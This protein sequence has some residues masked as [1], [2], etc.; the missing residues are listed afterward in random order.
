MMMFSGLVSRISTRSLGSESLIEVVTTGMVMRKMMSST[1]ITS[2]RGV[3]LMADMTA[4]SPSSSLEPTFMDMGAA[5]SGFLDRAQYH[6]VQVLAEGAHVVHDGFVASHQ[7]VV[8]E[9]GGYRYG[10]ADGGHEQGFTDRAGD[11]VDGGLAGDANRSER[12]VDAPDGAKQTNEWG[13]GADGGQKGQAPLG[14]ALDAF[15][16]TP[17]AQGDP[18]VEV[19]MAHQAVVLLDGAR[20]EEH[21]SE[22]QS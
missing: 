1:S 16:G 13:D 6:G 14:V 11:F 15:D 20:S 9:H 12:M 21:T 10:Q 7:P 4:S 19:N 2:T 5:F 22:L 3:V 17:D 18:V 8:S